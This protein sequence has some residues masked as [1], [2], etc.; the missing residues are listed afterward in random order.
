MAKGKSSATSATR[1]KHARKAAADQVEEPQIPKEKKA[2]KKEKKSK[3]PRKKVYIP[4]VKPAPVQP[5]PLDTLGIAQKLPPELLVVLR[6]LAKK[7]SITKRR[8]LEDL[9]A[10]WVEKARSEG[11]NSGLL[12]VIA[13]TIPVW[14]HHVPPLFLHPSRRIRLLAV[15]LHASLL[16]LPAEVSTRLFFTLREVL[17][18]D[19]TECILGSWLLAAHDVDRQVSAFAR[20][21]WIRC[22]SLAASSR[23]LTLDVELVQRLWNF[24]HRTLLDPGGVY[25]YVNPPQ[26]AAPNPPPGKKGAKSPPAKR[27]QDEDSG[28]AKPEEEEESEGDRRARLR[29]GACGSAV[30]ML[31]AI[32]EGKPEIMTSEFLAP[33]ANPALWT[34]LY[35]AQNP[36]FV[37]VESFGWIQPGVRRAAWSLLQSVL[38][39]CKDRLDPLIPVLSRAI[40]RSAWVEP[41]PNVR[42]AMWR[43]FLTFLREH[44]K[45]WELDASAPKDNDGEDAVDEDDSDTDEDERPRDAQ[46]NQSTNSVA[47][48]PPQAYREFLQFLELGCS[49]SPLQGYPTIIVIVSTIPPAIWGASS[50][51][52]LNDF[53]TS[54]WAAVDGR[55]LSALDRAATSAAFFSAL[56]ECLTFLVRRLLNCSAEDAKHLLHG[57]SAGET[58]SDDAERRKV[59]QNLVAE[60]YVRAWEALSKRRLRVE[61][62]TA[63]NLIVKSLTGLYQLNDQLFS[64]AWDALSSSILKALESQDGTV[65]PIASTILK[66]FQQ[67]FDKGSA[68]AAASNALVAQV[69]QCAIKR[70]EA[71]LQS[72]EPPAQGQVDALVDVL[73]E[74]EG[75]VF[76]DLAVEKAIDETVRQH[77]RR[78]LAVAPSLLLVYL[79]YRQDE[80]LCLQLWQDVLRTLAGSSGGIEDAVSPLLN[81]QDR[82]ALPAYLR[83]EEGDFDD[84][85]GDLLAQVLAGSAK[86]SEVN[87]LRSIMRSPGPF[88]SEGSF[89]GLVESLSSALNMHIPVVWTDASTS[90]FVFGVSWSLL[91]VLTFNHLPL[92]QTTEGSTALFAEVFLFANLLPSVRKTDE[93]QVGTARKLWRTWMLEGSEETR[94]ATAAVVKDRLREMLLDCSSLVSPEQILQAVKTPDAS[95]DVEPLVDIVPS[96][97]SL[98]DMLDN[99]SAVPGD[100]SLAVVDPLVPP[101]SLCDETALSSPDTDT[102]GLSRYA[103]VVEGLAL[104]LLD[105]RQAAKANAWALRHLLA[106]SLYVDELIQIPASK[107]PVFS[108]AVSRSILHDYITKARQVATYVLSSSQDEG[109]H[110]TVVGAI[111]ADKQDISLGPVGKLVWDLVN[112]GKRFDT[113]RE[114]RILHTI[115]EHIFGSI[116]KTEA[117]QWVQLARKLERQAPHTSLAI[118][119]SVTQYAPEPPIL[120]RYRNELAAG[121]FG[122]PPSKANTQGLWLL[123]RLA[124]IAPDPD[125][126]I[127]FMPQPRAVNLMKTCQQWITSD[128]D[129]DEDVES[130]MTLIFL[131]LAPILQNVPGAHWDLIFDVMENNLESSSLTEQTSL[132]VLSRTLRLF[133]A[134]QDLASTNKVLREVWQDRENTCLTLVRD[135]VSVKLESEQI[136]APLS[137]CRELALQIVQDLPESLI[138]QTTISKMCHIIEDIA[139]GVQK[140]AYRLLHEAAR[141]YTEHM[142]IEAAV[143]SEEPMKIELPLEL[144]QILQRDLSAEENTGF[145]YQHSSGYFL[146]WMLAFDHFANASLKV[147][148]A[149]IEQLRDLGLVGEHLLPNIFATLGLYGGIAKPFKLDIW[150]IEELYLDSYSGD[151]ALSVGLLAAHL[152]YRALL[153]VPSLIRNWLSECRD[154][155][156]LNRVS[157]YTA[158]HFSPAII[159]T[160]LAQVKDPDAAAE[161]TDEN[162]TIKVANAVNEV[163][164]SYAVDEYLLGL[165]VKLPSDYP[166][167]GIEI[168]DNKPVGVPEDRWRAW[169]L[170][171][172]Q[173]ISYRSG[174]ITDGL[175]FFKKNVSSHFEGLVECAICYSI[176]SAMD[177]SLPRKPCRTCKNRFHAGCLY[178]W[179]NSSH[180]SSCP[181]CRSE[182]I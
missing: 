108:A 131:H 33:F 62:E 80:A 40:L 171:I 89:K 51:T 27:T 16:R 117:E 52:P 158:A 157:T 153:I 36:P 12:E 119:Y 2:S 8:A 97:V 136:S 114:S 152:Y 147:K 77:L 96:E 70:C 134:I 170:G 45:A 105:D 122:V 168:R 163:T 53:F 167:H 115:L 172:Q 128:E 126:D 145:E 55:A 42:A 5:D 56:L 35:H 155:Q 9:Q 78:V 46:A 143:E 41:D 67:Q 116:S 161:F 111:I 176:I 149:Y 160:E 178:K 14:L 48:A 124:A 18:A 99:L 100:A 20:E 142:V 38:E 82:G 88:V 61:A 148:S 81:A 10:G 125:S 139:V 104:H 11:P 113:V 71:I 98:D 69:V 90:F 37:E 130:E 93:E 24:V 166:L 150:F 159:R 21:S 73:S 92:L 146:A 3:E 74:F 138:D 84:V 49:G 141:K 54:F 165:T 68:Q 87:V 6:R 47:P 174:S 32:V 30:W 79:S 173:I 43:P 64:A 1:K 26:P 23:P 175:S 101:A 25:L 140:M 107:S 95:F 75:S 31:S 182:I 144:V 28:R 39:T 179:F 44:P 13:E 123:R 15:G 121:L 120:D 110:T 19:Q 181:L 59:A 109:W 72:E 118:V 129:I 86:T 137:A 57:T 151:S 50:E 94:R 169:M 127:V 132:V 177:G 65:S 22:V 17:T 91:E 162:L 4:P 85:V 29:M 112:R 156:L 63:A 34:L 60:Q 135:L 103:R 83:A 102:S 58:A 106:L 154:R 76:S 66:A 133:I 164:A 7:D 180:S